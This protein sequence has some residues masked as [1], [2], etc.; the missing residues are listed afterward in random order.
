VSKII[1]GTHDGK[2]I[3]FDLEVLLRTRLL[4][5]ANSG[6]GKSWALRRLIEQMFG[7]VQ[8][9]VIDPEGEFS[10]LREKFG[11][12]LVGKGG[13]T[14]ADLRSAA[15]VAQKLLELQASAVCDIFEMKPHERHQWVKLFL[16]AMVNAPKELWHPVVVI[17]DEAHLFCPEKGQG[18]SEASGSVI[19]LATRGRKR[20]YCAI[21]ATQRLGKFSKNASA[22]CQ[23]ILIGQTFQ[24]ID[25]KRAAEALAIL[26]ADERKFFSEVQLMAPGN[27]YALGRA[28]ALERTLIKVAKVETTHPEAGNSKAAL[29]PATPEK[30]KALLPKLADLPKA[31]EEKARTEA[32]LRGEIRTLKVMLTAAQKATPVVDEQAT[33]RAVEHALAAQQR[34][35]LAYDKAVNTLLGEYRKTMETLHGALDRL[36][37]LPVPSCEQTA[38]ELRPATVVSNI[39]HMPS[40]SYTPQASVTIPKPNGHWSVV[41]VQASGDIT[42]PQMRILRALAEFEAIGRIGIPRTWVAVRAGASHTSSSFGNNLSSL[43]VRGLIDYVPAGIQLTQD[44][45]SAAPAVNAPTDSSEMLASC[46]NLLSNPQQRIL[47][48]VHQ[49][50]PTAVDRESLA[51]AA[52]ASPTSS[53]F[54]NNL[55]SLRT[56]GMIDY[57]ADRKVKCAEWMFVS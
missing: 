44:G 50:Y 6:G 27:F 45:R 22:E 31:A 56:A 40:H 24:D 51:A 47:Q 30:I 16:D 20:G 18:E 38:L 46:L 15:L 43:R 26:K 39:P 9:I 53:S 42:A 23:N 36:L 12:V 52:D 5:Q 55:S 1:L 3:G 54:G 21:F 10:T 13:E 8:I 34:N 57:T 2:D 4:I 37:K 35:W 29:P 33:A 25:R 41:P 11:F 48:Y 49:S 28:V 7:K 14:P 19:D 17:L 32:D